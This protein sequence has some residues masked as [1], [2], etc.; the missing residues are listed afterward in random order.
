MRPAPSPAR[1]SSCDTTR[2]TRMSDAGLVGLLLAAV[3]LGRREQRGGSLV[4]YC[5]LVGLVALVVIGAVTAFGSARDEMFSR[6]ASTI[7]GL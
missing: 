5:L 2:P 1:R 4:D 6:S 3:A 7:T